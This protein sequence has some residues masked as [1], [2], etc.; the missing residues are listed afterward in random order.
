IYRLGIAR[1]AQPLSRLQ[2]RFDEFQRR[3]VAHTARNMEL[4][5]QQQSD[6]E[7]DPSEASTGRQQTADENAERS[8][9]QQAPH[10]TMLGTKRS[11]RSVRSAAANTLPQSQRG[12]AAGHGAAVRPNSRIPVFTDPDR[13]GEPKPVP[14]TGP[15]RDIGSDEGRRK[16][17]M[18]E[19][20]SWRGQRLEQTGGAGP[21]AAAAASAPYAAAAPMERFTVFCDS[22]DEDS[23]APEGTGPSSSLAGL[24]ARPAGESAMDRSGLASSSGLLQ[25]LDASTSGGRA[26]RPKR[27]KAKGEERMVMPAQLLFPAGDEVPQCAEEARAQLA[28][29][30]F[31]YDLWQRAEAASS[32]PR[33]T[34]SDDEDEDQGIADESGF[35][36]GHRKS[37]AP[38]SPTINTRVAQKDMLGIWNDISDSDSDGGG[39]LRLRR[40]SSS[41]S[42]PTGAAGSRSRRPGGVSIAAAAAVDD[43]YQFTMG[44]VTPHV[45]PP[46]QARLPPVIPTSTRPA[47]FESFL[48]HGDDCA[49]A[50]GNEDNPPTLVLNSIRAAK[51]REMQQ[52]HSRPTPLAMRGQALKLSASAGPA[53]RVSA[54][55]GPARGLRSID[56]SSEAE[57]GDDCD[58]HSL[59]R[60]LESATP[61]A[62]RI[63]VFRDGE[64][65]RSNSSSNG[66]AA[67]V[68]QPRPLFG[69]RS[70]S[71][72]ALECDYPPIRARAAGEARSHGVFHS[73]P[74]HTK[75]STGLLASGMELTGLSGFTGLST[76][77][78]PTTM[79][80][81]AQQGP[82][83]EEED[84]EDDEDGGDLRGAVARTPMRKRL[85]MAAKDLGRITPRFPKTPPGPADRG[86]GSG[87]GGGG[88]SGMDDD[89][90]DED[91]DEEDE[92]DPCTENIGE[93]GELDSQM[94]DLQMELL[95]RA[96]P[97]AGDGSQGPPLFSVFRD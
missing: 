44:P 42:R 52:P 16:E 67:Q 78:G 94:N 73:T 37:V 1:K 24:A 80:F 21:V 76:I 86:F 84:D 82:L 9:T 48:D 14:S 63:P 31:D 3:I 65:D 34:Y 25:S 13:A 81:A 95:S 8:R 29:Y 62:T 92:D 47:R 77:G 97:S 12:L 4:Q 57:D 23:A 39:V 28:Q 56:E 72:S 40:G 90:D 35:G 49:A 6:G 66:G 26:A 75:T 70:S 58:S 51:R 20:V 55:A 5:Q 7:P 36:R 61:H 27:S 11:G 71:T 54:S 41:G 68:A 74:G 83:V 50:G 2:R 22:A 60:A 87:G 15:W 10:R 85:S 69:V 32:A 64:G 43:D 59:M 45:V 53:P 33:N 30:R 93:F 17:N 88:A 91:E 38:S 46:E 89:D 19:A 96:A 18:R 79:T